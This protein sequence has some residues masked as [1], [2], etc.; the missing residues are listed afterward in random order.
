MV[1]RSVSRF[2]Y[3]VTIMNSTKIQKVLRWICLGA[4]EYMLDHSLSSTIEIASLSAPTVTFLGHAGFDF[5]HQGVRLI[6]DPWLVGTAFDS[7]WELL[8][9]APA[10]DP[11]GITHIWFSHEHPDHFSPPT[12]K[13]IPPEVRANVTAIMQ[14]CQDRR[15]AEFMRTQGYGAVLEVE[16]GAS[17]ALSNP[18]GEHVGSIVTVACGTG[19]SCHLL[20]LGGIR[21]LNTN[22][23]AFDGAAG[24]A[25]VLTKLGADQAPIDLL[26]SQFSYANWVGNPDEGVL[27]QNLAEHKLELLDRQ[28]E[29]ARP[30]HVFPC[31]SFIVFAHQE[32]H[33]L[34]DHINDVGKV[35][36]R[37][38]S[39]GTQPILLGNGET[40][41]LSDA[42]FAGMVEQAPAIA[43]L[44]AA[45]ID[46][47]RT[48][49]RA[50]LTNQIVPLVELHRVGK[51]SLARL[52]AGV[53]RLDFALMQR[54]LSRA[55]FELRDHKVL[56][57]VDQL[58]HI[59]FVPLGSLSADVLLS[60][61]AL[62]YAFKNDF[63]FET[64]LINGRFEK[65][66]VNGDV[67]ILKLTGQFG[68]LRRKESLARSIFQRKVCKPLLRLV[69]RRIAS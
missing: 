45:E 2:T 25:A 53:S 48:G 64:L 36:A 23:C 29:V 63:G 31:A 18:S 46:R 65:R 37:L 55:V 61:S 62:H 20:D 15:L 4:G 33:Y 34:N 11:T 52:Q 51:E 39:R 1:L 7:G 32:N 9:Q 3:E 57:V 28:V 67:A 26:I 5:R 49:S 38:A 68:Y 50:P 60:S 47:V 12:L 14:R 16:D 17:I 35:C 30:R 42:G 24:F 56:F 54:Q 8:L 44:I 40:Y 58:S 6:V 21:M 22:D 10:F 59:S 13:L 66:R 19:D 41:E 43:R 27:R 69:R